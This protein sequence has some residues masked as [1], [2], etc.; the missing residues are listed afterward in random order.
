MEDLVADVLRAVR[1]PCRLFPGDGSQ[2]R[3]NLLVACSHR[4][5]DKSGSREDDHGGGT[6]VDSA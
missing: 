6:A 1:Y 2:S 3:K 4:V 5:I